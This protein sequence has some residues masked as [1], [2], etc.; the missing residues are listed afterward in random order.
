[1]NDDAINTLAR[2]VATYLSMHPNA[3]D[4]AEGIR[5]WWLARVLAAEATADAQIGDVLS[6]LDLLVERGVVVRRRL[7]GGRFIYA[8]TPQAR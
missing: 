1:M 5:R 8:A 6:A 2:E 3:A 4:T 7:P